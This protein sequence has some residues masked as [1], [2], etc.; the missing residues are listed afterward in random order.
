MWNQK[1]PQI[2]KAILREKK[3]DESIRS[4]IL[5]H[6]PEIDTVLSVNYT[7]VSVNKI[8]KNMLILL[9]DLF[10]TLHIIL[11]A[12]SYK[13]GVGKHFYKIP[14]NKYFRLC[15]PHSLCGNYSILPLQHEKQPQPTC[16]C[17]GLSVFQNKKAKARSPLLQKMNC[18][19]LV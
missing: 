4:L 11:S 1:A 10:M 17:M 14:D 15:R 9:S 3:K 5:K 7:S 13:T 12:S 8:L 19:F 6:T 16:K 2:S 18:I